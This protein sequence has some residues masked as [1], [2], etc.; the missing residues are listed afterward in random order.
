MKGEAGQ[1]TDPDPMLYVISA[2][3][4]VVTKSNGQAFLKV[5]LKEVVLTA[6]VAL[7]VSFTVIIA[8][9]IET[10][11]GVTENLRVPEWKSIIPLAF[12]NGKGFPSTEAL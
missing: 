3:A 6:L 9:A 8:L 5:I 7:P 11:K 4:L 1:N 2:I 10:Y 12:A